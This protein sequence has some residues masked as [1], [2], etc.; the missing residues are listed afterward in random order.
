MNII[1]AS[2]LLFVPE[3]EAFWLLCSIIQK[4]PDY[5]EKNMI[6]NS[7]F[8]YFLMLCRIDC[9]YELVCKVDGGAFTST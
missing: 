9:W 4:V 3:E 8:F 1:T 7:D 5:Y 6:G 2:L